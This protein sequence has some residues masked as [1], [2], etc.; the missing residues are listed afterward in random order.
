[1]KEIPD[2][3]IGCLPSGVPVYCDVE[4]TVETRKFTPI[5]TSKRR[6]KDVKSFLH[7]PN[8]EKLFDMNSLFKYISD[9]YKIDPKMT[10]Y[11]NMIGILTVKGPDPNSF[12]PITL[13][14]CP[15]ILCGKQFV[16]S[17]RAIENCPHCNRS[18][19]V[20]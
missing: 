7:S 10:L 20:E 9:Q 17:F 15:A 12:S 13:L 19:M 3:F 16:R 4:K 5:L 18:F 1:M 6:T 14:E 11:F 8:I 2:Y